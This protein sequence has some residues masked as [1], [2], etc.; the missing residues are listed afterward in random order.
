MDR[1]N[2][3]KNKHEIMTHNPFSSE[4]TSK[5]RMENTIQ[6]EENRRESGFHIVR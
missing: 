1:E 3:E 4:N 5:G 6:K 2:K